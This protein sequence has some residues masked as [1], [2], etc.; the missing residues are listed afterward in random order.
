MK[1]VDQDEV[2]ERMAHILKYPAITNMATQTQNL[3]IDVFYT[4]GVLQKT[5]SRGSDAYRHMQALAHRVS[6]LYNR[7][8][9]RTE[10]K[11]AA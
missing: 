4:L 7:T 11:E 2:E 8:Y 10:W 9:S 3:T 5:C 1:L 6:E